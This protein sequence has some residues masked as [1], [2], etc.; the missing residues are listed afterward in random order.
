MTRISEVDQLIDIVS[1][2]TLLRGDPLLLK[3][4]SE[5]NLVN[6]FYHQRRCQ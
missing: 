2:A 4:A 5:L 1:L 3:V 6:S